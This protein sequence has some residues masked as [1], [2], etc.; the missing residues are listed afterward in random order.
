MKKP[1]R[2]RLEQL[3]KLRRVL[4]RDMKEK[5]TWVSIHC[6]SLLGKCCCIVLHN[7]WR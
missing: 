7:E 1:K 6:A 2:Y 4:E 5:D 3:M